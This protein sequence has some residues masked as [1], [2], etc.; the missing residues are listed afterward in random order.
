VWHVVGL[1]R[2]IREWALRQGWGGR[3]VRVEQA[4]GILVAALAERCGIAIST[5][6][7]FRHR[8]LRAVERG[9]S[10]LRG[11]VEADEIFIVA[12]CKGSWTWKRA[13]EGNPAPDLPDRSAATSTGTNSCDRP[14]LAAS[15]PTCRLP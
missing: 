13:K 10:K 14:G 11:I 12:S 3:P 7:R 5:A 1:Q 8:F 2:S 9:A 4:Q 15:P 6:F